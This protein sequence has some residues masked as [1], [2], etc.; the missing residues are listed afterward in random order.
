M[1]S[2]IHNI[3]TAP[4][5]QQTSGSG[6]VPQSPIRIRDAKTLQ[7]L[8]GQYGW[9]GQLA[10]R[11]EQ[12]IDKEHMYRPGGGEHYSDGTIVQ[13][14]DQLPSFDFPF[15]LLTDHAGSMFSWGFPSDN[16]QIER[17]QTLAFQAARENNLSHRVF[18]HGP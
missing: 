14:M 16:D 17:M 8:T 18:F 4:Y 6:F 5:Q 2:T 13:C 3:N 11:L 12:S 10:H 9:N 15:F 1:S 7:L